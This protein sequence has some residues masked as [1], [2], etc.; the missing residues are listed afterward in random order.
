MPQG[1]NCPARKPDASGLE[2]IQLVVSQVMSLLPE[3]TIGIS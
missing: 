3:S 1:S 2:A